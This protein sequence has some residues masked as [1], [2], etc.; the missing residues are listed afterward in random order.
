M[1]SLKQEEKESAVYSYYYS[2]YLIFFAQLYLLGIF[3]EFVQSELNIVCD[4]MD[5]K[6]G[7]EKLSW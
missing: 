5:Q 1:F 6:E 2:Y 4:G 3:R 7:F